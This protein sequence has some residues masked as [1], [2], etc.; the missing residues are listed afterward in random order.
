M[1]VLEQQ[2][3]VNAPASKVFEYIASPE[4][5][6]AYLK[7]IGDLKGPSGQLKVGDRFANRGQTLLLPSMDKSEVTEVVPGQKLAYKV[8]IMWIYAIPMSARFSWGVTPSGENASLVTNRLEK[9]NLLGLPAG[10]LVRWVPILPTGF[11]PRASMAET[12]R[13]LKA[14]LGG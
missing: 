11:L 12:A 10:W 5:F 7:K 8:D 3:T 13:D 2:F 1:A 9:I 14:S 4:R 6:T